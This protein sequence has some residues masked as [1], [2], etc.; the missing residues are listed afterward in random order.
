MGQ[1][2]LSSVKGRADPFVV[3]VCVYEELL[4]PPPPKTPLNQLPQDWELPEP[5]EPLAESGLSSFSISATTSWKAL[6]T[7]S[8]CFADASVHAHPS[9]RAR[10]LPSS[11]VTTRWFSRSLLLPTMHIGTLSTPE[12]ERILSRMMGTMSKEDFEATE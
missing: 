10:A 3:C 11:W 8:L 12:Y 9:L 6:M 7:L 1:M 4:E 2:H 5:E